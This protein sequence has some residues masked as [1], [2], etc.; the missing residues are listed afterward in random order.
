MSNWFSLII[1]NK[2]VDLNRIPLALFITIG[3]FLLAPFRLAAS[4]GR[5]SAIKSASLSEP[6]IFII[7]HWRSGTTHLH[8]LMSASGRFGGIHSF[9]AFYPFFSLWIRDEKSLLNRMLKRL[10][11]KRHQDNVNVGVDCPAEEEF[12]VA[13]TSPYSFFHGWV[14]KKHYQEYLNQFL[15]LEG[16][17]ENVLAQ[18]KKAYNDIL[19]QSNVCSSGKRLLLKNPYNTSKMKMLLSMYPGAKFIYIYRNPYKVYASTM[20][21]YKKTDYIALQRISGSE[22]QENVLAAYKSLLERFYEEV[23]EI[24]EGCCSFIKYEDLVEN[25]LEEMARV[26]KDIGLDGFET[27]SKG[28][29]EYLK[30]VKD[31]TANTFRLGEEECRIIE[32][33]WG[34]YIRLM[35]Y[36][37]EH[38]HKHKVFNLD[39]TPES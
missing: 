1:A 21:M 37:A 33:E 6:P 5:R 7:G 22:T 29:I 3:L 27:D 25:P 28:M 38:S 19:L 26:Y 30:S 24:P 12:A 31:Y 34:E 20:N 13:H 32:Q 16:I 39:R 2:G 4:I 14:F 10:S 35:G 23:E 9:D 18:W 17:S 36:E 15:L 11:W 8:Y